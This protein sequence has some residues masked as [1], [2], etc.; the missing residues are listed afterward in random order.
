MEKGYPPGS[1]FL[2]F[3]GGEK[4]GACAPCVGDSKAVA[5]QGAAGPRDVGESPSLRQEYKKEANPSDW[6]LFFFHGGEMQGA[7]A[8][9]V[10]AEAACGTWPNPYNLP[11]S[12][13]PG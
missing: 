9:C 13:R 5:L 4:Q 2:L 10:V 11:V 7:C 12:E 6:P 8:P 3:R 1:L